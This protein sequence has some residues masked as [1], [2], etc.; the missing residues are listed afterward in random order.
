M[1]SG[2]EF[3]YVIVG[4]GSAGCVLAARLSE[5]GTKRVA[6][7][8]AGGRDN[9]LFITM[10]AG[11]HPIRRDRRFD[12][13]FETEPI[14]GCN[15]RRIEWPRGKVLGGSS[16]IN[17]MIYM[18]GNP[19]D[20][21]HWRQSGLTG[22]SYA[23]CLPYFKRSED[24]AHHRDAY[25]GQGGPLGVST[26]SRVLPLSEAFIE[27]GV[28][29]GHRRNPDFNGADQLGVGV[30]QHSIEAGRRASTARAYLHPAAGRSN[31]EVLVDAQAMRVCFDGRRANAVE[32]RQGGQ[33][34]SV[35]AREEVILSGGT[36][37]SPQLLMLSG[38]GPGPA[39]Q[40]L[41]IDM[42]SDLPGVGENVQDHFDFHVQYAC[43]T[44]DTFDRYTTSAAHRA[45]AGLRYLLFRDGPAS[46]MPVQVGAFLKTRPEI[47]VPDV[48]LQVLSAFP[49]SNAIRAPGSR[50]MRYGFTI[51]ITNMRPE[52]RGR[53]SLKS[54]DPFEYPAIAPNYLATEGDRRVIREGVRLTREIVSQP[55]MRPYCGA[56]VR[57]GAQAV[58]DQDLDT[59]IAADGDCDFHPVGSCKMG[60]SDDAVVDEVCRV[61]GVTGL[62]V[63]DASVM[64]TIVTGNT[65]APTIMIAEKLSDV[66]RGREPLAPFNP[67]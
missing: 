49:S 29:A 38:I 17:G 4:A 64:P 57:P 37:N 12:W 39:L 56:E 60:H 6:L 16:S 59:K 10:P 53:I 46:C 13:R 63:V 3:D 21:D 34:R 28:E 51:H 20:Y 36:V 41:G 25:H 33:V 45:W 44:D 5:D 27:A 48:Q 55:A 15:G 1:N 9:H 54:A 18:R 40:A 58:S 35:A 23:E 67:S 2:G 22:W 43:L 7:L 24:N 11:V 26:A 14:P 66:I 52:S 8:E 62:R 19:L 42:V 50:G 61:R 30:L 47:E 32:Y 31:L 65:N